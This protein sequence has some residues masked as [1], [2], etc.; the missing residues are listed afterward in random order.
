MS[1]EKFKLELLNSMVYLTGIDRDNNRIYPKQE[2]WCKLSNSR[3]D[4]KHLLYKNPDWIACAIMKRVYSHE[5][6]LGIVARKG[7]KHEDTIS[8]DKL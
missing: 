5:T 6:M 8:P 1:K 3:N 2:I 4:A 7:Y